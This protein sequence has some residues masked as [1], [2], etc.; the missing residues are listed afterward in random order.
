[1]LKFA[2]VL[3]EQAVGFWR[4]LKVFLQMEF[5]DTAL[6]HSEYWSKF[7]NNQFRPNLYLHLPYR[8]IQLTRL[9]QLRDAV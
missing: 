8:S 1:M 5:N 6:K 7:F 9:A 4:T 2:I 3:M